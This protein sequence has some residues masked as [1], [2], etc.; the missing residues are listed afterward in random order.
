MTSWIKHTPG[1]PRPVPVEWIK[2]VKDAEGCVFYDDESYKA[3]EGVAVDNNDG[4]SFKEHIGLDIWDG[5]TWTEETI[6]HF[7]LKKKYRAAYA[8]QQ[9]QEM[10]AKP[11]ITHEIKQTITVSCD[12]TGRSLTLDKAVYDKWRAEVEHWLRGGEVE[13]KN[14]V[15]GSWQKSSKEVPGFETLEYRIKPRQRKVGEVWTL[16]GQPCI[17]VPKDNFDYQFVSLSGKWCASMDNTDMVYAT[18]SVKAYI[19]RG[20]MEQ[21]ER[22]GVDGEPWVLHD[23]VAEACQY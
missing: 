22:S 11:Q 19:A 1:Q 7:K 13:F 16:R 12:D 18:P 17:F 9:E 4:V 23:I 3:P 15:S 21:N 10:P 20:F 6:T 14:K 5:V 2:A 8:K